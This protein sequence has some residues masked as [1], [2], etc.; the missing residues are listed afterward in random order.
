MYGIYSSGYHEQNRSKSNRPDFT[1]KDIFVDNNRKNKNSNFAPI[2]KEQH[3]KR[4]DILY[5]G[6]STL[7]A[8]IQ[9]LTSN[10]H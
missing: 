6:A 2:A 9:N 10:I 7:S 4:T 5:L 1:E 8:A 3:P